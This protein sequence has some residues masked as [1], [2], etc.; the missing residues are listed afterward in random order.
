MTTGKLLFFV[1]IPTIKAN[2]LLENYYIFYQ[3]KSY[4]N[5]IS[6]K[7]YFFTLVFFH[8]YPSFKLFHKIFFFEQFFSIF[9]N[10]FYLI[11]FIESFLS[12]FYLSLFYLLEVK[13]ESIF[14]YFIKKNL[15]RIL[16]TSNISQ[17]LFCFAEA[18]K[19]V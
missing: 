11:F 8:F 19:R 7:L 14:F 13:S 2:S 5:F 10:F 3:A 1:I 18:D 4:R 17:L 15:P 12:L 6:S 9:F 16:L